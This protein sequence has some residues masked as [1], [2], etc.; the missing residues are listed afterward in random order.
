LSSRG[1]SNSGRPIPAKPRNPISLLLRNTGSEL[2]LAGFPTKLGS[3]KI[4]GDDP[5]KRLMTAMLAL[6]MSLTPIALARQNAMSPAQSGKPDAA[7][8][9]TLKGTVK[10]DGDKITFLN[11]KDGKSW[12]VMNPEELKGHEGHHVELSAHVYAEKK[13]IHVMSVKMLNSNDSMSK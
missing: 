3:G 5:M 6:A 11:E 4:K 12:D 1:K 9:M 7:P 13:S 2:T 10:A 8:L